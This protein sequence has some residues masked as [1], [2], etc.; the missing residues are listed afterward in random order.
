MKIKD[1][2]TIAFQFNK[3]ST[4]IKRYILRSNIVDYSTYGSFAKKL[5]K[6]ISDGKNS[7]SNEWQSLLADFNQFRPD[8]I[9]ATGPF[10][11]NPEKI[12]QSKV[13]FDKNPNSY[14]KDVVK[15]DKIYV[16]NGDVS[17]LTPLVLNNKIDYLTHVFPA[18]TMQTF[19]SM[20]VK[21]IKLSGRDGIALY[22]NHLKKP[23]NNEKVRQA[24]AYIIDREEVGKLAVPGVTKGVKYIT[25]IGKTM[26]EAWVDEIGELNLYKPSHNKAKTLLS[27][28][29]LTQKNGK[30][31]FNDNKFTLKIQAPVGWSDAA[32]AAKNIA[33]QL[34]AFG[35]ET[36]FKG[37][38]SSQRVPNISK[39]D[40]DLALSFWGTGQPHPK[41][42]YEGPLLYS[43][44]K[45]SGPGI[46][47]DMVQET[48]RGKIN[49]EELIEDSALGWDIDKQ[50]EIITKI[51][52]G[53]NETLPIL[54]I[55]TKESKNVTG[56]NIRSKWP[57]FDSPIYNNPP[58]VDN[59][60]IILI[61]RGTLEPIN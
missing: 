39:G 16:Y 34:S 56:A 44:I 11:L 31:Y 55:Y 33:E 47:F 23:L 2:Y 60:A 57:E 29:G 1:K 50:K 28:A 21:F 4:L 7:K 13:V 42:A 49:F 53:F 18:G 41:F 48:G 10:Y 46:G 14:L 58:G 32:I 9:N 54:P 51:A 30:W 26:T 38:Q 5:E 22:Y 45:A 20:G 35:I 6:I 40:F 52:H 12:S 59:F 15:F 8:F 37:I 61:L 3:G 43:N 27:E 19:E 17:S 25:G 24:I 36:V